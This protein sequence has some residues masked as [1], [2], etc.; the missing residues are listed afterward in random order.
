MNDIMEVV[1]TTA[2]GKILDTIEK[3]YIYKE[4]YHNN[5]INDKN[6]IK[7]NAI[8]DALV[9]QASDRAHTPTPTSPT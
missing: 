1:Y 7:P 8:F 2:K 9:R 6:T 5:Q 4:T 3:Y